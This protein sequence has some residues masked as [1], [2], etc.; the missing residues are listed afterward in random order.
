MAYLVV[1]VATPAIDKLQNLVKKEDY[2]DLFSSSTLDL[3]TRPKLPRSFGR[4]LW[5]FEFLLPVFCN[6]WCFWKFWG[7]CFDIVVGLIS[8]VFFADSFPGSLCSQLDFCLFP[9]CIF[10]HLQQLIKGLLFTCFCVPRVLLFWSSP[11]PF[12]SVLLFGFFFVFFLRFF[13]AGFLH[14]LPLQVVLQWFI[15][16]PA[17]LD[18]MLPTMLNCS[19][20]CSACLHSINP[21]RTFCMLL[22]LASQWDNIFLQSHLLY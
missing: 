12:M 2:G 14:C 17:E 10:W 18:L 8:P 5:F 16:L 20:E 3:N 22:T 7:P 11:H 9:A 19:D 15:S 4:W 1:K 6:I 21:C 13:R